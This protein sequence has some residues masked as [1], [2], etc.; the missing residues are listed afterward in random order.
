MEIDK[1]NKLK[2][3]LQGRVNRWKGKGEYHFLL[4]Y[5]RYGGQ[6]YDEVLD[7]MKELE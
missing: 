7:K 2:N 3:W 6:Y 1:W 4:M 5:E